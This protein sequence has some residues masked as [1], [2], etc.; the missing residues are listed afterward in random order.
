MTNILGFS[1]VKQSG[2]TTCCKFLHGY[3]LR[4]HDVVEKFLMDE[5][6]NLI[7]NATQIDENGEEIEG[8]GILDIE[9]RDEDFIEY[10][11]RSIW[12]YVRS[13]SFAD[14]LKII[15]M[16]LFGLTVQ[17][18]YG[19]DEDKNTPINTKWEDLPNPSFHN[20]KSDYVPHRNTGF[21]TA[22]ECL[23]YFGTDICR[24]IKPNIWVDSCIKR[25]LESGTDLAIVPDVRFPN[26]AEAIKK[27]GGKV[28]RLTRSPHD[29]Q[30]ESE[31][32]LNGY[33]GFDYVLDNA[34]MSVDET[35]KSLMKVLRGW[36]WLQ[37]KGS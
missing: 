5:E 29:D 18:C 9:R 37:T 8:L 27:A 7:V 15:S 6:S 36:G 4:L 1:G 35:N 13:F 24:K 30:H 28:V 21:M 25:M 3:Q 2:K 11:S 19:T 22:R 10:A 14:P 34:K 33:E 26:E 20:E 16:E 23:Q 17:Q 12:P 31:T 32:A